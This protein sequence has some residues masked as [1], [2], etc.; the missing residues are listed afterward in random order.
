M[1]V[2]CSFK[3]YNHGKFK[4]YVTMTHFINNIFGASIAH[5]QNALMVIEEMED[6]THLLR[7]TE[8]SGLPS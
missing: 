6:V 8:S 3:E 7:L 5:K 1:I 4:F 2:I